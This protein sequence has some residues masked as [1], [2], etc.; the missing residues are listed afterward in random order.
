MGANGPRPG[1]C[2]VKPDWVEVFKAGKGNSGSAAEALKGGKEN[3]LVW[4]W[5]MSK[6]FTFIN[7]VS[8]MIFFLTK[9]PILTLHLKARTV[10]AYI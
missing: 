6:I 7:C 1:K 8:S 5:E 2:R 3:E 9:I 10:I 4:S